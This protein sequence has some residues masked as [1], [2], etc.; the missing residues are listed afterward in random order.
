MTSLSIAQPTE[1]FAVHPPPSWRILRNTPLTNVQRRLRSRFEGGEMNIEV[2]AVVVRQ[3]RILI[4]E[5]W[6]NPDYVCYT[7][8]YS[9]KRLASLAR[10]HMTDIT[11]GSSRQAGC[12][13]SSE[14]RLSARR[15]GILN[16]RS[17][18]SLHDDMRFYLQELS[19]NESYLEEVNKSL[20]AML[21]EGH[22]LRRQDGPEKLEAEN[23]NLKSDLQSVEEENQRS[24]LNTSMAYVWSSYF[25]QLASFL[26]RYNRHLQLRTE[27]HQERIGLLMQDLHAERAENRRVRMIRTLNWAEWH[28][29]D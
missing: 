20:H 26:F 17:V 1:P 6:G 4:L 19:T 13:E 16:E 15:L 27:R 21:E 2:L 9:F 14:T 5:Q 24:R 29:R 23:A 25:V 18:E 11:A 8:L 28:F 10:R 3:I 22:R 7:I 12:W